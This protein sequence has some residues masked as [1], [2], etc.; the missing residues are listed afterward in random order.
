MLTF[1]EYVKDRLDQLGWSGHEL[2]MAMGYTGNWGV[3][4]VLNGGRKPPLKR[5]GDWA[6]ALK[7]DE[8][9][10]T[11]LRMLAE[12]EHVP[13]GMRARLSRLEGQIEKL[14]KLVKEAEAESAAK[15]EEIKRL[16]ALLGAKG[17]RPTPRPG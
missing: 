6:K 8:E 16:R 3:Y 1:V 4:E 17:A 2:A 15:D 13:L 11:T 12:R 10:A 5:I 14:T 9:Q 7:L